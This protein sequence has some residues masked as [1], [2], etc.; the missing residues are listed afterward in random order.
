[1]G[2]TILKKKPGYTIALALC[3]IGAIMLL[4]VIWKTW[5]DGVYSS[6]DV[7]SALGT[8]LFNTTLGIGFGLQ[9][10]YYTIFGFVLLVGGVAILVGR[11]ERVT[12]V[13][14]VSALVECPFCKYQWRQSLSKTHLES[15]GYP[16]VRT[17]SRQKCVQCAKFMRPKIVSTEK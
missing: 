5:D 10:I 12:V 7:L 11:R 1:M 16:K 14:E 15:M 3:I 13:E 17:L 8:S 6:S 4:L 9:L 2:I